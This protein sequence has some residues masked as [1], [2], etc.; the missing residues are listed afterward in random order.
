MEFI[1]KRHKDI[2]EN[3]VNEKENFIFWNY[4]NTGFNYT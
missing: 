3:C 1:Q 4:N 2:G